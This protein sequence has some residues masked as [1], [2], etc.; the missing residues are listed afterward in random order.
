MVNRWVNGN[1]DF[2]NNY[3]IRQNADPI[4]ARKPVVLSY[5][6]LKSDQIDLIM[7]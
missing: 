1:S 3:L 7:F 4:R 2:V 6:M 5:R